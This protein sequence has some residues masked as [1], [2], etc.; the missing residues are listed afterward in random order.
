VISAI[1]IF[2]GISRSTKRKFTLV[3]PQFSF[4]LLLLMISRS[5][6][7][8]K[9][10][11][12]TAG[13]K[14]PHRAHGRASARQEEASAASTGEATKTEG[15]SMKSEDQQLSSIEETKKDVFSVQIE[16]TRTFGHRRRHRLS[17]RVV[18]CR[19]HPWQQRMIL[20]FFVVPNIRPNMGL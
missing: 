7:S 12:S 4:D 5:K 8:A 18:L 17:L 20:T 13:L 9:K 1:L 19:R 2:S 10:I 16:Q 6:F 14:A 3:G 15:K 11:T